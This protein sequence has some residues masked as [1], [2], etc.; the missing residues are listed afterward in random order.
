MRDFIHFCDNIDVLC[1]NANIAM[2]SAFIRIAAMCKPH[3]FQDFAPSDWTL[4]KLHRVQQASANTFYLQHNYVDIMTYMG[5]SNAA[6]RVVDAAAIASSKSKRLKDNNGNEFTEKNNGNNLNN[7]ALAVAV[8][9]A[10]GVVSYSA[11]FGR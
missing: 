7:I 9:L 10:G 3:V 4:L 5:Y 2:F 11:M 6:Y 1:A 8:L